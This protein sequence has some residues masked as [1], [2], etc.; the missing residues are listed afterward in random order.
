MKIIKK[1]RIA[2][3]QN[4]S[5]KVCRNRGR[6]VRQ[7]VLKSELVVDTDLNAGYAVVF[8]A[9]ATEELGNTL[10]FKVGIGELTVQG[11]PF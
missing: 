2:A 3:C 10:V 9:L 8:E 1:A 11:R 6:R 5:I 7:F 4:V